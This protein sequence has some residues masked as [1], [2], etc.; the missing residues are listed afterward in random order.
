MIRSAADAAHLLVTVPAVLIRLEVHA[1]GHGVG[2]RLMA[3][4]EATAS[5]FPFTFEVVADPSINAFA[6]PGGP[7]FINTG[8]L[9]AVDNEAQMDIPDRRVR[10]GR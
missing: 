6:L 10:A 9:R 4:Q 5:G 8:L 1:M 3:S 7:M 2:K